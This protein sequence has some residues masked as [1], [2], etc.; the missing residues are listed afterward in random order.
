MSGT[1]LQAS[2]ASEH[3]AVADDTV[4][5]ADASFFKYGL[6]PDADDTMRKRFVRY[7]VRLYKKMDWKGSTLS[8]YFAEDFSTFDASMFAQVSS[9]LRRDLPNTLREQEVYVRKTR[10]V[11]IA[12]ALFEVVQNDLTWPNDDDKAPRAENATS[13]ASNGGPVFVRPTYGYNSVLSRNIANIL[14]SY[15]GKEE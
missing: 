15:Y 12:D 6:P 2:T 5:I 7:C 8:E 13:T 14:K 9:T 10:Q 4:G 11:L 1:N 3:D